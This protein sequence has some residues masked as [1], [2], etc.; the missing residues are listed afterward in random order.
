MSYCQ[1]LKFLYNKPISE[2]VKE[3]KFLL[4]K[5][6]IRATKEQMIAN[7]MIQLINEL[8]DET[9]ENLSLLI[10]RNEAKTLLTNNNHLKK[11]IDNVLKSSFREKI[12]AINRKR[13]GIEK[14]W[15]I[16]YTN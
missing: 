7:T 6:V 3:L 2:L 4:E 5:N 1:A 12:P 8:N 13:E 14:I 9:I 10:E 16:D 11:L 15:L